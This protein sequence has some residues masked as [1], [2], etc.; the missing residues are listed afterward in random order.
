M[1]HSQIVHSY[2]LEFGGGA[3]AFGLIVVAV[4]AAVRWR[5][6]RRVRCLAAVLALV[7]CVPLVRVAGQN[8]NE[9][10]RARV[11]LC[12]GSPPRFLCG[13]GGGGSD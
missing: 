4:F 10:A 9:L 6:D 1:N 5:T 7:V 12:A 13:G 8:R 3:A 2:L 11:Q